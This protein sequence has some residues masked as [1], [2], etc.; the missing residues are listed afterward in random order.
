VVVGEDRPAL[1]GLPAVGASVHARV[2]DVVRVSADLCVVDGSRGV[3]RVRHVPDGVLVGDADVITAQKDR[4]EPDCTSHLLEVQ[5][6][7]GGQAIL[8]SLN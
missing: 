4:E 3:D 7:D 8:A 5:G 1:P 6:H 2:Q